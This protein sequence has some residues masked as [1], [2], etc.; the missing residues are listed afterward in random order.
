MHRQSPFRGR[1]LA[2]LA[3]TIP[4]V[5]AF[6]QYTF[7]AFGSLVVPFAVYG[8]A[9]GTGYGRN[10]AFGLAVGSGA[11]VALGGLAESIYLLVAYALVTVAAIRPSELK[12]HGY[13]SASL[14]AALLLSSA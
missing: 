4:A 5:L 2:V 7:M 12:V 3:L 13:R 9:T 10:D 14:L 8:A 11:V 6:N 1:W